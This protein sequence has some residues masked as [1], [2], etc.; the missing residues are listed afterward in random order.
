MKVSS[1]ENGVAGSSFAKGI[2]KAIEAADA[3]VFVVSGEPNLWSNFEIDYANAGKTTTVI[4]VLVGRST[5]MPT[6]LTNARPIRVS[7][8]KD[9]GFAAS[10]ILKATK[11]FTK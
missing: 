2:Q 10:G 8:D 3:A 5:K 11:I 6:S 9:V 1:P 7:S 4:P